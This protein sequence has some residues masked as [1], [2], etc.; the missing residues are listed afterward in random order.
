MVTV[1]AEG[2]VYIAD[3]EHHRIL[4][5]AN[6]GD[7]TADRVW[8][9]AGSF[10]TGVV[11]NDGNGNSGTPSASSLF[12]PQGLALDGKGRLY[13]TDTGNNRALILELNP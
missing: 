10:T 2:G 3:S 11:N 13:V 12:L 1:D 9:Q 6:D 5:F 8:G 4:Y 7:T